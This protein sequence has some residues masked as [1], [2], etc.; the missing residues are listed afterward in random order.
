MASQPRR[1]AQGITRSCRA[2]KR[3]LA[4]AAYAQARRRQDR[5]T[6]S[7]RAPRGLLLNAKQVSTPARG[8]WGEGRTTEC[9][10]MSF[11]PGKDPAPGDAPAADAIDLIVVP[12]TV[13]VGH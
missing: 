8:A 12:R 11:F 4:L 5:R 13:D 2:N 3:R 7:R 9:T 1:Y 10:I 6:S